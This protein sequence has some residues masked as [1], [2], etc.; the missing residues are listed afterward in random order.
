MNGTSKKTNFVY[1]KG[2]LI[3]Q[4]EV[5]GTLDQTR[6]GQTY[7]G[8]QNHHR[9]AV[10]I[11][12][13]QP[14]LLDELK[15]DFLA[16]ARTLMKLEHPHILRLRDADVHNHNPFLV[17]SYE[18]YITLRQVYLQ[19]S[20][21]PLAGL[22]P[23]LKQ[24]A[25]ALQYAHNQRVLHGDI[26]P[27]NILLDRNNNILLRGFMIETI[28]QN[29]ERLNYLEAGV[30]RE[31]VAYTAPERIQGKV[32]PA[33]D[34]YS[35]AVLVYELLCGAVPF[36]GS[37]FEVAHQQL[38][39]PPSSPR[40]KAPNISPRIE[41]AVMKALEKDP[42][43]RFTDIQSFISAL[44]Q[45]QNAQFRAA[46]AQ[47]SPAP[48][49]LPQV[50]TPPASPSNAARPVQAQAFPGVALSSRQP[51]P[52]TRPP[53][54]PQAPAILLPQSAPPAQLPPPST[55]APV[56]DSPLAP[57]R[58]DNTTM[59]RRAFTI[60]LVGLA[61]AGGA[62]GWYFLTQRLAKPAPPAVGPDVPPP[63]TQT[64]V[65]NT[66]VLIFTGHL[67]GVNALAWSPDGKL[68]ASASNDTYVQIFD[69]SSGRRK[70][71]Y[72]GHS[73]E[74]AAVAWSPDSKFIAS[75]GQ[76]TTVQVWNA[77]SGTRILTYK[78]HSD[79]VNGVSWSND[80]QS[81]ASGSEDKTVQVW[82][83]V[84][85]ALSLDFHGHTAGVLCV[86]WQPDNSSVASGS[87]DG[88]LRDWATVQ[89]GNHFN[90][91]DQV[92][93]YAGHG[94]YEVNALAWSPDGNFIVSAGADQTFQI[95]NGIDGTPRP[96]FFTSHVNRQHANPV[97]S[98]AWSPDGTSIASGDTDGNV[99]VWKTAGRK[100][101]FIYRGHK[102]AVNALAWSPDGKKIA[103]ASADSTVH[104]WQP[105]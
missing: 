51:T 87:W 2:Q 34:Q 49:V 27:E 48:P 35:L 6:L 84:S 92:F 36:T 91:G 9:T 75:G 80:S 37:L 65:N 61:A 102:G 33:S 24:I 30:T 99:Y 32:G 96:P 60:G 54:S 52:P 46:T 71:I 72:S 53:A 95:S 23:H 64:T 70:I 17:A 74:V 11:E 89:H 8:Q 15:E 16:Q 88:T 3:G 57:R 4:Y 38:H 103:S 18:P 26:R 62:G 83:A 42:G 25:S 14:P 12:V 5:I 69:A 22:L 47:K 55:P 44:E 63:A 90:A 97:L 28:T 41:R 76:D 66:K 10:M 31:A 68:I 21:Q 39:T 79:R 29:R 77:N 105:G 1:K 100:T 81:I 50:I 43:Q 20:I 85:A 82:N 86:G 58:G 59:T 67:A 93:S 56:K 7:L 78:G 45:E 98:V 13:L 19:G 101:F 94:N 73:E 104:V 40:Q